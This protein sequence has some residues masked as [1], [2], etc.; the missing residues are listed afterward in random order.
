[1]AWAWAA[2]DAP[3]GAPGTQVVRQRLGG[4]APRAATAAVSGDGRLVAFVSQAPLVPADDNT[5]DDIYALDR[6]TGRLTLESRG[7]AGES[8]NGTSEHPRLSGDGRIL[9]FESIAPALVGTRDHKGP[10]VFRRDRAAGTTELVSR[11][12]SGGP[13]GNW[14]GHPDVSDDGRFVVFASRATDLVP[15]GD[16]NGAGADVY[17]HDAADGRIR[18]I[19]VTASGVHLAEGESTA[20][21][22]SGDG[23]VVAFTSSAPL[24][25]LR[26]ARGPV[27]RGVFVLDL[28][29]GAVRRVS[30][31]RNGRMPDGDSYQ[32]AIDAT[33]RRVAF[34]STATD[35]DDDARAPARE[36]VYLYDSGSPRLRLVSRA[37]TGGPADGASR[38][39]AISGDG[40]YVVF[41]S[42]ASN[43]HCGDRCGPAADLN[44][45]SDVFRADTGS[46]RI[47]R[48]SGSGVATH[49]PWWN[50]ST[51]PA[52]DARGRIVAFSSREPIH[53]ADLEHD[54][55]LYV[56]VVGAED[57]RPCAPAAAAPGRQ[58]A[59]PARAR[60]P[61]AIDRSMRM[62]VRAT[63]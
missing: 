46:G 49:G 45:V 35:L 43:L 53:A 3:C 19:S 9:V 22:I 51:G 32:P 58:P 34:V 54:D 61:L 48:I 1:M 56:E 50:R 36:N 52:V 44:L 13:A 6:A 26:P 5:V 11:S 55:D 8:S 4:A 21:V 31:A 37:A 16:A 30:V 33:G 2:A 40:R 18:R 17:L 60:G 59:A 24:D 63:E 57:G 7:M 42:D 10:Q 14:T 28:A 12:T 62:L 27:R 39:P 47:E 29:T 25:G 38:H 23:R 15:G 20:P 41:G